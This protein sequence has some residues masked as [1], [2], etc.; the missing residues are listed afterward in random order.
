VISPEKD[1]HRIEAMRR[2]QAEAYLQ[3]YEGGKKLFILESAELLLPE[4]ANNLLKV[5][6]EPPEDTVFILVCA[7]WDKLLPT[8]QSRCQLFTFGD[9]HSVVLAEDRLQMLMPQTVEFL[10]RLPNLTLTQ[11]VQ[12]SRR[13]ERDKEGWLHYLAALTRV[14]AQAAKGERTLSL[15]QDKALTAALMLEHT[16][17]LL[18]RNISQKLLL[19]IIFLRLWQY[20]NNNS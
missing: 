10:E 4:A 3:S 2:L 8:I 20:A 9:R 7:D 15:S 17:G 16:S 14:L 13:E 5:L 19:D 18:R 6:E 11:A 12:E 1:A